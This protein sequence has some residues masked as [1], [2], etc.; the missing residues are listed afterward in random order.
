M[1][2]AREVIELMGAYPGRDFRMREIVNYIE[3]NDLSSQENQ[4]DGSRQG[5]EQNEPHREGE[6]IFHIVNS[7]RGRLTRQHGQDGGGQGDRV[8]A[9]HEFHDS[10]RQA[11]RCH[12]ALDHVRR[13]LR[14][15]EHIDLNDSH[16]EKAR[17]D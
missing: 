14:P 5:D 2:Y 15:H 13:K 9:Q 7:V 12:A 6:R 11:Q 10:V 16:S 8:S 3:G 17:P 1:K 4:A